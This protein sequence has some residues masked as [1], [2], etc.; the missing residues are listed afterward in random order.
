MRFE[1]SGQRCDVVTSSAPLLLS[2][3]DITSEGLLSFPLVV[4][5]FVDVIVLLPGE[6]FLAQLSERTRGQTDGRMR[7]SACV[8]VSLCLYTVCKS[9]SVCVCVCVC[10]CV[11]ACRRS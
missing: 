9:V 1:A 7:V 5:C 3:D 6:R 4:V 8:C 11:R 2:P 10:V